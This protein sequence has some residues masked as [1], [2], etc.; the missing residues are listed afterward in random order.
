MTPTMLSAIWIFLSISLALGQL[1]AAGQTDWIVHG[2]LSQGLFAN[3]YLQEC[4]LRSTLWPLFILTLY[5]FG[6]ALLFFSSLIALPYLAFTNNAKSIEVSA[7]AQLIAVFLMGLTVIS[8]PIMDIEEIHC[9][10]N[11]LLQSN[12]CRVGW[13]Y[14]LACVLSLIS[15]C[16]PLMA[17]L[18]AD[19]RKSYNFVPIPDC[20]L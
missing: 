17:R 8:V 15:M 20:I 4:Q 19:H 13:A 16:C 1:L 18:I 14:A 12:Y 11:Q 3:C 6:I 7:N 5:L 9:T 2:N 10:A